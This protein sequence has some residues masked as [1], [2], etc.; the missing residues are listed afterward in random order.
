M[1][2]QALGRLDGIALMLPDRDLF[3]DQYVRKEAV[4]S[5]YVTA[6]DHGLVVAESRSR[7]EEDLWCRRGHRGH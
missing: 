3:V 1:A 7:R 2:N 6:L 4:L 5:N